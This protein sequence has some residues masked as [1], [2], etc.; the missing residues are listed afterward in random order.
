MPTV[1]TGQQ[2][3]QA[4]DLCSCIITSSGGLES[5]DADEGNHFCSLLR[6]V[7]P[8]NLVVSLKV[9]KPSITFIDLRRK[10]LPKITKVSALLKLEDALS[11][12]VDASH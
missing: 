9:N 6:Q 8:V 12:L 4:R 7:G 2:L 5:L 11:D 1:T 10:R 3:V